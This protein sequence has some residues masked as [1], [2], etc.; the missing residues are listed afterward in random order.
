M[1]DI[2][3]YGFHDITKPELLWTLPNS[4][5]EDDENEALK[6]CSRDALHVVFLVALM[7]TLL[8]ASSA[9]FVVDFL[10]LFWLPCLLLGSGGRSV[11]LCGCPSCVSGCRSDCCH[12][13]CFCRCFPAAFTVTFSIAF[14]ARFLAARWLPF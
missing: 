13:D 5:D 9:A 10:L 2:P 6:A 4:R 12:F 8:A 11:C 7:A 14:L 1:L 3:V